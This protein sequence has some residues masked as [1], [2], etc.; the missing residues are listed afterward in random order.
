MAATSPTVSNGATSCTAFSSGRVFLLMGESFL[1]RHLTFM[2]LTHDEH[3]R[4]LFLPASLRGWPGFLGLALF[5]LSF[6]LGESAVQDIRGLAAGQA[7][8]VG[9][10]KRAE[11][12]GLFALRV[13]GQTSPGGSAVH[14]YPF[15]LAGLQQPGLPLRVLLRPAQRGVGEPALAG[16]GPGKIR[17][18]CIWLGPPPGGHPQNSV[19]VWV[20]LPPESAP[21]LVLT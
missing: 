12:R 9:N 8:P 4:W 21:G 19:L 5:T 16:E 17:P 18:C 7:L 3:G 15:L 2:V 14:Q 6:P 1:H 11:P 10:R 20:P 13:D